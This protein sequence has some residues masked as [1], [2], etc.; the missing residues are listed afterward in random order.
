[1][2]E[3]ELKVKQQSDEMSFSISEFSKE[4]SI[5]SAKLGKR[6]NRKQSKPEQHK[7]STKE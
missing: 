6:D 4:E 3:Q 5:N 1:M 2:T 7:P